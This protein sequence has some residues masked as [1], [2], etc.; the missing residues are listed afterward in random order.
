M[1]Q[2]ILGFFDLLPTSTQSISQEKFDALG[3][4]VADL[5]SKTLL[6]KADVDARIDNFMSK[7]T[8]VSASNNEIIS[9]VKEMIDGKLDVLNVSGG[10]KNCSPL[11]YGVS[12]CVEE[13]PQKLPFPTS[14]RGR[15]DPVCFSMEN[16][17]P[18]IID[19][20]LESRLDTNSGINLMKNTYYC[21]DPTKVKEND[22]A[23][24]EQM[25]NKTFVMRY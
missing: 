20:D 21:V 10:H 14:P 22:S 16:S 15:S 5:E 1:L 12:W 23:I 25:F 13:D 6:T 24:L 7:Q 9:Q 11:F 18:N 4:R 3:E 2:N 8:K 17:V 19:E